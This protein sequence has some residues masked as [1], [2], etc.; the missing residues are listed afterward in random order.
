MDN[1]DL[2]IDNY[3][4]EDLLDLFKIEWDYGEAEL[5][6]CKKMVLMT[7]PDKSS[8]DKKFFLF[9]KKAYGVLYKIYETRTKKNQNR[10]EIF[11]KENERYILRFKKNK[12]FNKIF[13]ELFEQYKIKDEDSEYGYGDWLMSNDDCS[14]DKVNNVRDMNELIEAKKTNIKAIV[15]HTDYTEANTSSQFL[16]DRERPEYYSSDIFSKLGYEDLKRAHVESVIPVTKEDYDN[17]DKFVSE[18]ELEQHRKRQDF[19]IP[20]LQESKTLLKENDDQLNKQHIYRIY[21]LTRES[22]K[23]EQRNKEIL[24]RFRQLTN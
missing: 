13:N 23:V 24:G 5:K 17:V 22:E 7:H 12:N 2:N 16:L 3:S 21:K 4:L 14:T 11:S 18:F 15:K 8:L 20:T 6:S 1:L 9:F 19:T 10:E